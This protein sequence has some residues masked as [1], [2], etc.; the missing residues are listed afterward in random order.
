VLD[1]HLTRPEEEPEEEKEVVQ[2]KVTFLDALKGLEAA[3]KYIHRFDTKRSIILMCSVTEDE[4]YR[5]RAGGEKKQ[6]TGW[7]N[8]VTK[9]VPYLPTIP[10][11]CWDSALKEAMTASFHILSIHQI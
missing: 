4:L 3:R 1:Q 11:K 5:L 7:R 10:G 8:S 6:K 2:P 9:Y